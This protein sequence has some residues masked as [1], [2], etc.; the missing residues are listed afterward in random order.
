MNKMQKCAKWIS[1]YKDREVQ[2]GRYSVMQEGKKE[3]EATPPREIK[4]N[5]S[6]QYKMCIVYHTSLHAE[7]GFEHTRESYLSPSLSRSVYV[8]YSRWG[9]DSTPP[10]APCSTSDPPLLVWGLQ[11]HPPNVHFL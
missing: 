2:R 1:K 6:K 8:S 3:Y 4:K 10:I 9:C 11:S 5:N 7:C